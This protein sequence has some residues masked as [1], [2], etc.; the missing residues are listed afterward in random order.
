ML[1]SSAY[2]VVTVQLVS[3]QIFVFVFSIS[4]EI[5]YRTPFLFAV[6]KFVK[7]ILILLTWHGKW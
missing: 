1:L 2:D 4:V 3:F 5:I 6:I 7:P